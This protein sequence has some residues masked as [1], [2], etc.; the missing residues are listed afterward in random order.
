MG[1]SWEVR[2]LRHMIH[3][4]LVP[5]LPTGDGNMG[6]TQYYSQQSCL[7]ELALAHM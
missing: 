7:R 4:A 5:A 6:K 3:D 2:D 1:A